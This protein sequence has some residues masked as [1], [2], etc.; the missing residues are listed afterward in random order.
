M[1]NLK[2]CNMNALRISKNQLKQT[3][4]LNLVHLNIHSNALLRLSGNQLETHSRNPLS[5]LHSQLNFK[6]CL[7]Q[8][9]HYVNSNVPGIQVKGLVSLPNVR[10]V[11]SYMKS[12]VASYQTSYLSITNTVSRCIHVE[13]G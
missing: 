10:V 4:S 11:K 7:R 13:V 3:H 2:E 5:L 1:I 6:E 9:I 8:C 12:V